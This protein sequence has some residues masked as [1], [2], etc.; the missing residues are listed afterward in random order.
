[1]YE[2][3][4]ETQK[5][6][7]LIYKGKILDLYKDDISLPDGND[8]IREY[9]MHVGAACIVPVKEN[10]NVIIEKQF[11]YP[12]HTVLTE[13]P[14]GIL[15]SKSE[16]PEKAAARELKEETGYTADNLIYLGDFYPTCA[17]SDENIRMYLA[18][19]LKKGETNLDEDEFLG[20]EEKPLDELI[21]DVMSGKIK[22]GKTQA[23]LLKAYYYINSHK[24]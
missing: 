16:D 9:I 12:F 4:K 14:A 11:R 13:I 10:G 3:L 17:Y 22:D 8:G 18:W 15:D 5:K 6:S 2:N 19:G 21:K 7:T 24:E 20:I 23:A 1:M